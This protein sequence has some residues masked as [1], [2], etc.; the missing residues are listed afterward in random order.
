MNRPRSSWPAASVV[1]L[2]AW[3][4]TGTG[5]SA[6]RPIDG[7]PAP[8]LGDDYRVP[9]RSGKATIDL[10]LLGQSPPADYRLDA[11][12]VLGVYID[13]VLGADVEAPPIAGPNAADVR[14]SVGYPIEV[15]RNGTLTLPKIGTVPVRGLTLDETRGALRN[16]YG[17]NITPQARVLITL[18]KPRSYRVLVM[19]QEGTRDTGI[20]QV[21]GNGGTE[22]YRR[23]L[24][25]AVE[26]P[27]YQNDVL[28]AL[29]ATG[30]LPGL[31]AENA[32]YVIRHDPVGGGRPPGFG[33]AFGGHTPTPAAV[34]PYG[35]TGPEGTLGGSRVVRIPLKVHPG[36]PL[37]FGP[38]DVLLQGGDVV[39][40]ESRAGDFFY[41]SGLLGGGQYLLPR[42]YDLDVLGAI[43]VAQARQSNMFG[44]TKVVGGRSAL[45]K[46]VSVGASKLI[47]LRPQ[48][49]GSTLPIEVDLYDAI[50]NPRERVLIR[51]GDHLVLQYS[52]T[53]AVA[54]FFERHLFEGVVLGVSSALF[55]RK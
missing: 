47:I 2:A 16:V 52:R 35:E 42:D 23:N 28:H 12:D 49:D 31:D 27:A 21:L 1:L 40:I 15:E 46:D 36:E 7:V 8:A 20:D 19:R 4:A 54:A 13:G 14:P 22:L 9:V 32:V 48:P 30:G 39:Y 24:G 50:H 26:L 17:P 10:S 45:N 41:T 18:Q 29:T 38:Q 53:E 44:N 55:Y 34:G 25:Q 33:P 43:A 3:L 6:F 11:G 37:P 51:P 5:C